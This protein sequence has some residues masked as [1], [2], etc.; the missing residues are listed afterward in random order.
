MR[1]FSIILLLLCSLAVAQS[2][3]DVYYRALKAEEAGDVSLALKTF[4]EALAIPGPYTAEIQ[5]IVDEYHE[6]LG[7]SDGESADDESISPWE[8]HT[9]GNIAF[10]ALGYENAES[11]DSE[12]GSE[13]SS[14]VN[15]S[16]DYNT[17][18]YIH[19]FGFNFSGDWFVDKE[20]MPSL[21]TSSWETSF[22]LEYSL[23]GNSLTFDVGAN[24]NASEEEDLHPDFFIWLEKYLARFD[25]HKFGLALWGY[26]NLEG[27]MSTALYV[28]WHRFVKYG[29]KSAVYAGGRFEGDSIHSPEYLLKWIG[30]S[31]KPSFSYKFKT[32]ISIDAKLNLFYGFVVNGPD[33]DY[34]KVQKFSSSWGLNVAWVPNCFGL[35]LG[36]DQFY[37]YYVTPADYEISYSKKSLYTQFKAGV[38]WNI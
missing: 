5:E 2:Q 30:P 14:S 32:E 19:S 28:S 33:V 10:V 8:F 25:S 24:M 4:E 15:V 23:I 29:W 9:Y 13:L 1:L 38:K 26:E 17:R 20:D 12:S 35:F 22:G 3:E 11:T 6:A 18:N 34:E 36:L 7:V 37:K 27:P 16:L 31:F 21:D